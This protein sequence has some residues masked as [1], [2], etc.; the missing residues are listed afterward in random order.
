VADVTVADTV[1]VETCTV[2]ISHSAA[3][4]VH[5]PGRTARLDDDPLDRTPPQLR[6]HRG[7]C[8]AAVRNSTSPVEGSYPQKTEL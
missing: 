2:R 1:A 3:E 6:P 8:V 5:P 7:W 4:I